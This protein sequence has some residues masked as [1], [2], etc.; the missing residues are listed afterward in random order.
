MIHDEDHA[1]SGRVDQQAV[2]GNEW[3]R[4]TGDMSDNPSFHGR[5]EGHRGWLKGQDER[6][7]ARK[8]P[9]SQIVRV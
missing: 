9:A 3:V 6:K 8:L 1:G 4:V 5:V 7:P 2:T